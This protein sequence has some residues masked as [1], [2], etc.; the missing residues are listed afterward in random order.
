[1]KPFQKLQPLIKIINILKLWRVSRFPDTINERDIQP[2]AYCIAK[3]QYG[4]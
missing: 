4:L 1:M 2:L 3:N